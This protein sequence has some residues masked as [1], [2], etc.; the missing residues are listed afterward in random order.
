MLTFAERLKS[1]LASKGIDQITLA[2]EMGVSPSAVSRWL[3]GKDAPQITRL[4]RLVEILDQPLDWLIGVEAPRQNHAMDLSRPHGQWRWRSRPLSAEEQQRAYALLHA[5]LAPLEEVVY[6]QAIHKEV[7]EERANS[8]S[9]G[10]THIADIV[11]PRREETGDAARAGDGG[12]GGGGQ[13]RG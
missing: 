4:P 3:S 2:R 5:L 9:A 13:A 6:P 1:A 11:A 8:A 10:A 7:L 12:T